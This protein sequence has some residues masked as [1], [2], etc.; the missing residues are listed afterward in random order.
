MSTNDPE[1]RYTAL[2]IEQ[3]RQLYEEL[4]ERAL[5]KQTVRFAVA[6][7]QAVMLPSSGCVAKAYQEIK[8]SEWEGLID[9]TGRPVDPVAAMNRLI[10]LGLVL[11][12]DGVE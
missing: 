6:P 12:K 1:Y 4:C 3:E 11:E 10:G 2:N 5:T 7:G 8:H 9:T